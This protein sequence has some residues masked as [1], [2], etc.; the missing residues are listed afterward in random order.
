MTL[1][2]LPCIIDAVIF[3]NMVLSIHWSGCCDAVGVIVSLQQES[4]LQIL[5]SNAMQDDRDGTHPACY[6]LG[7]RSTHSAET[8]RAPLA[9]VG[10]LDG[11]Q[12]SLYLNNNKRSRPTQMASKEEYW[13]SDIVPGLGVRYGRVKGP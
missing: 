1:I 4:R 13:T 2:G 12:S 9:Q 11:E 3:C 6:P 5:V 10:W 7:N 8:R